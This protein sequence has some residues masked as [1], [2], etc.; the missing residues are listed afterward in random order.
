MNEVQEIVL[1]QFTFSMGTTTHGVQYAL[2]TFNS[3]IML[4]FEDFCK[5]SNF[6]QCIFHAPST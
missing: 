5:I 6:L 4:S 2:T 1:R 3:D